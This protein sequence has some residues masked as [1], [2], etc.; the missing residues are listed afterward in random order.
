MLLTISRY[1]LS[2]PVISYLHNKTCIA[3]CVENMQRG[4]QVLLVPS[5]VSLSSF[6]LASEL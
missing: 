5:V 4:S 2:Q 1:S 3:M 6:L